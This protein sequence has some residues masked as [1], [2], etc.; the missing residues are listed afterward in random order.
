LR[1]LNTEIVGIVYGTVKLRIEEILKS[2]GNGAENSHT[3]EH[4]NNDN[5][6]NTDRMT[7]EKLTDDNNPGRMTCSAA[8][9]IQEQVQN[10]R[11]WLI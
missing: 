5:N 11:I 3:P 1:D 4:L 10:H 9:C 6:P 8:K 7:A 2:I